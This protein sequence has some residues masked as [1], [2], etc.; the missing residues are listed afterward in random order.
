MTNINNIIHANG[1]DIRINTINEIDYISLTDIAK[2]QNAE[3]PADIIKNWLRSKNTIEFLGV[4]EQL[5]NPNFKL[6]EFDQFKNEAGLNSF[7]LSPQKWIDKTNAI[8]IISKSGRYGG[9]YAHSDIAFEF[10]SWLSPT[11]K[12]YIIKDYQRLKQEESHIKELE[13]NVKREIAK[14]NYK[15]HTDAIK[16]NL[17]PPTLSK[18]EISYIYA[19]EADI[20]N[21]A[22]FGQTAKEWREN[23]PKAK[24]NIR[25]TATIEQLIVLSNLETMNAQY[26]KEGL[27]QIERLFKLNAIAVYQM[28]SILTNGVKSIDTIKQIGKK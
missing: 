25:D 11:F 19:S 16:E 8:G 20:I 2:K 27:S 13:W 15:I 24:G 28:N 6:V 17:I 14:T 9:T 26:I 10:A 1:V 12:L 7:V 23:N 3:Y 18:K 5:N 22:L 21:K 4:W